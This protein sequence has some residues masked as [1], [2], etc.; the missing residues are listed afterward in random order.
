MRAAFY[1]GP[2]NIRLREIH[3]TPPQQ[4]EAQLRVAY[5]GLCGTDRHIFH[6][7][8]DWR[9]KRPQV[10][11]HE[12]SGTIVDLGPGV[13]GWDVGQRVTVMPLDWCG[14]CPACRAGH[15]HICHRLKFL[16]IDTP[17]AFQ[18]LWNVPVR[19]LI[20][21]PDGLPLRLGSLIEPVAVACHDVRLANVQAGE[22]V[23][24]IGG[25]PVGAL[26]AWVARTAGAD[27]TIAEIQPGR[28]RLLRQWGFQ[29]VD[30]M[31]TDLMAHIEAES[32]GAGADV[33]FE[34]S[35]QPAGIETALKLPRT[36]GRVVIV[37]I[38][39]EPP[40]VDLFRCFWRELHLIGARVY[41]REDFETAI[42][43]ADAHR[44]ALEDLV[45]AVYPLDRVGEAF[46]HLEQGAEI[47]KVLL[48]CGASRHEE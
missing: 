31:A 13:Q 23:V 9:V 3:P 43:W 38:F 48:D 37:G 11:G 15:T 4:G 2:G 25:G 27:V 28:L 17:G 22:R 30:P 33:V 29:V 16:G 18:E 1:E 34:V 39:S 24:V 45:S 10:I 32:G 26:I 36:R 40:R 8:M 5:A 46:H 12:L 14:Q 47:M 41:E 19:T 42:Q 20:P 7:K 6:G 44:D 21:L 35:A